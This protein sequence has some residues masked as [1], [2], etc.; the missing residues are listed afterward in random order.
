MVRLVSS[1]PHGDVAAF[2]HVLTELF[3]DPI[4]RSV[5]GEAGWHWAALHTWDRSASELLAVITDQTIFAR[6]VPLVVSK[7]ASGIPVKLRA[8]DAR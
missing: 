2:A 3:D 8:A 1:C 7:L 4:Q 5:M 6:S